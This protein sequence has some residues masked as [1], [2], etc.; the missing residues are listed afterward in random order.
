MFDLSDSSLAVRF[1]ITFAVVLALIGVI[2]SLTR[3]LPSAR[4]GNASGGRQPQRPELRRL[5]VIDV[6]TVDR[7]RQVVLI[8]RD[9]IEHLLLIGGP[10]DVVIEQNIDANNAREPAL[11]TIPEGAV[12]SLAPSIEEAAALPLLPSTERSLAL[13]QTDQNLLEIVREI[14]QQIE[15]GLHDAPPTPQSALRRTEV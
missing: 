5:E 7:F 8:R 4:K 3:R 13:P 2:A 9:N 15:I 1:F 14:A 12:P 11:A 10:V 6:A